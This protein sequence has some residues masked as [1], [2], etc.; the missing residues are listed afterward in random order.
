[1]NQLEKHSIITLLKPKS[2]TTPC[3]FFFGLME[4]LVVHLL[5]ME[6]CKNSDHSEPIVMERHSTK[7][8][9]LGTMIGNAL[10]NDDT[11]LVGIYDYLASHAI[12]SDESLYQIKKYCNV[13]VNA[14]PPSLDKCRAVGNDV[15][16]DLENIDIYNIYAPLCH[17]ANLTQ[18]PRKGSVLNFDPC[19]DYYVHAYLN[20]PEVQ[21][22]LHANVTKLSY[23][24]EPCSEVI[25]YWDDSP[26]TILPLLQELMENGLRVWIF[27]G[28]IDGRIPVTSTKYSINKMKLPV[29]TAWHP[30]MVNG[31]VGGY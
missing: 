9:I 11:D 20:I 25:K 12:I 17:N 31:E 29:K 1:M 21:K 5:P 7:I 24:W 6:Q 8:N 14:T 19:S 3:L 22:A 10:I 28:D 15:Y 16:M 26:S 30:W 27:S 2:L 4:G 18:K 23:D 13:G